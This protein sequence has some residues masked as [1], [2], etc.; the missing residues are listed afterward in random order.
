MLDGTT[1]DDPPSTASPNITK[2]LQVQKETRLENNASQELK[3]AGETSIRYS[4][5]FLQVLFGIQRVACV[6]IALWDYIHTR[7]LTRFTLLI[8]A[9]QID[10]SKAKDVLTKVLTELLAKFLTREIAAQ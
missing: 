2:G 6:G 7:D 10:L 1:V 3:S 4:P 8:I 9:G 5:T